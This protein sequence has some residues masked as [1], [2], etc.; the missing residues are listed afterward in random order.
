MGW[1]GSHGGCRVAIMSV[2]Y[3]CCKDYHERDECS[4]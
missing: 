3:L 1:D 4:R 2:N